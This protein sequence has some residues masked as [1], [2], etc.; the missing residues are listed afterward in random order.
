MSK[1]NLSRRG[2]LRG[3]GLAGS[4]AFASPFLRSFAAS[5]QDGAPKPKL[6]IYATPSGWLVGRNG[7]NGYDGWLPPSLHGG[8]GEAPIAGNVMPILQP[9]ERHADKLLV[10]DNIN[11]SR[12]VGTHQQAVAILTG[13]GVNNGEPARAAGGDGDFQGDTRSIDHAIAEEL[14][15]NVF[16]MAYNIDGFQKGEGYLSHSGRGQVYYPIQDHRDAF[17]RVFAAVGDRSGSG[18]V[19][20]D[21][22]AQARRTRVF[23]AMRGDLRRL[24]SRLPNA[25]RARLDQHLGHVETLAAEADMGGG[26]MMPTAICDLSARPDEFDSRNPANYPR[27]MRNYMSTMVRSMACGYTQVGFLQGGNLEGATPARWGEFGVDL[28]YNEHAISHKFTGEGGAGSDGL[29]QAQ[30]IENGIRVQQMHNTLMAELLD[31]LATTP[32]VDGSPMLD[33][34]LVVHIKPMGRNH[35]RNLM[36]LV[37]GGSSLGVRGGR[38]LRLGDGRYVNDMLVAVAQA[39]GTGIERFGRADQ[40]RGPVNFG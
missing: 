24:R 32:D 23:D 9:L 1:K 10:V 31:D 18:S 13:S 30:A 25:D 21:T 26:P 17:D 37:A 11:G 34:T 19:P 14:G 4:A 15:S 33:H 3:F 20:Q 38:Y 36:W 7:G 39:M 29:S 2:L 8:A 40:N 12:G 27:L 28:R 5:A 22:N 6:I 35:D 16:G